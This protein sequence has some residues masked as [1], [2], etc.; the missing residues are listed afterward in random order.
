MQRGRIVT[1]LRR[2][3]N[4]GILDPQIDLWSSI[5]LITQ[6]KVTLNSV[7]SDDVTLSDRLNEFYARFDLDNNSEPSPAPCDDDQPP[8]VVSD[9]GARRS[10]YKLD[11]HKASGPDGITPRL[12]KM[13]YQCQNRGFLARGMSLLILANVCFYAG[14][15]TGNSVIS[16]YGTSGQFQS[17]GYPN[18]IDGTQN[19]WMITAPLH[20]RLTITFLDF[21]L[22]ETPLCTDELEVDKLNFH[23]EY[24]IHESNGKLGT[25]TGTQLH[26][27][28]ITSRSNAV[29]IVLTAC[30]SSYFYNRKGIR[31]SF[32]AAYA[33]TS[34]YQ[35]SKKEATTKAL[36]RS[37]T[38]YNDTPSTAN[39]SGQGL[40]FSTLEAA[41]VAFVFLL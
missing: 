25:Y 20:F 29:S 16:L 33:T 36:V 19:T 7:Q 13:T 15:T 4:L 8:F 5:N 31:V 14:L 35:T 38:E 32:S 34:P 12:L 27:Q 2:N 40:L 37:P 6:Y 28:S 17:P 39:T 10:F 22:A 3:F 23:K 9:H 18:R 26:Q 24:Q 41:L 1:E 30:S 11:E 21:E